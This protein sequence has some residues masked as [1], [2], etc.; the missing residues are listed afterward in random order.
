VPERRHGRARSGR[1]T[2]TR[3]TSGLR[4]AAGS[5]GRSGLRGAA[6][7]RGTSGSRGRKQA[8]SAGRTLGVVSAAAA[9]VGVAGLS[10]ALFE[11]R[12]YTLRQVR[13]PVLEPG[14]EDVRVLHVSDL[15]LVPSQEAKRRWVRRLVYYDPH[16]VIN[17][18]DN[19]GHPDALP[20]VLDAL[21][22][23]LVRPGAFVMGSNDYFSPQPKNPARYLAGH[24]GFAASNRSVRDIP[25]L[26]LAEA[27]RASGWHDLNNARA[28]INVE[29]REI[30]LVGTGDAHIEEDHFPAPA[31]AGLAGGQEAIGGGSRA[32]TLHIGVTHAP[33]ARVLQQMQADGTDIVFAGHTHGGQLCVPGYGALVTNCDLDPGRAKGLHGWP[34]PRPDEPGGEES[35]WLHVSA[36]LGTSPYAP[37]RFGCRPEA[38][39]VTLTA[40]E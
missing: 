1:R 8:R 40:R 35:M 25:G 26:E 14:A 2:R 30:S 21:A 27:F 36:G 34:G 11:A 31:G 10:W 24:T 19:M 3:G 4:R 15:H 28:T 38:S 29:G 7:S 22:P 5:R 9:A 37:V 39:L 33:Y 18:G 32:D 12:W 23:F 13:V 6:G 20:A 16:L 17:T